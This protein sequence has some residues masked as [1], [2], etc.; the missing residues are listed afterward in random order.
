M[1]RGKEAGRT[2][3]R[4]RSRVAKSADRD[5]YLDSA[6]LRIGSLERENVAR[7]LREAEGYYYSANARHDRF[8]GAHA[9]ARDQQAVAQYVVATK[10]RA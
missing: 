10:A 5:C 8:D 4:D 7:L 3:Q 2:N 9:P 1:A 6:T